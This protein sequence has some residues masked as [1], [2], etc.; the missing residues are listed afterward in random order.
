MGLAI[1]LPLAWL[2]AGEGLAQVG[3]PLTEG[4][5]PESREPVVYS[6]DDMAPVARAVRTEVPIAIDGVL[7][8]AVWMTAPE[9]TEFLQTVPDEAQPVTEETEVRILYDDDNIYVG[10]WLWDEGEVPARLR[11]RDQGTP[12]ADYFVVI[13]DSY[14]DHRTAY[15]FAVSAAGNHSDEILTIGRGGGGR[16]GRGRGGGGFSDR[17]WD[18]VIDVRTSITD[19]GWFVEWRI[20]FSQLRYRADE[21]QT[22]GLQVERKLRRKAEDTVWAF[23]PRNEPQVVARYGHLHGI[24]GIAQGKRTGTP[25]LQHG[26]C[27]IPRDSE[28]RGCGVRQPF[29]EWFGVLHQHGVGSQVSARNEPHPGCGGEPRLRA[30]GAR[31]GGDQPDSVRDPLRREA[32]VL[33]GGSGDVPVRGGWGA[34]GRVRRSVA[35]LTTDRPHAAGLRPGRGGIL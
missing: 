28:E 23:R 2:G 19:D 17:S 9:I 1:A 22:W 32:A 7:D 4:S 20:P 33:R 5:T 21:I 13:F 27:R 25:P 6:H 26:P 35:L 31:P 11:R 14:H 3:E 24:E 12:D 15:R 29:P 10:A 16:G 8:E 30:G 18:P 34:L